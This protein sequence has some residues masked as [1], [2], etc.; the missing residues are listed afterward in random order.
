MTDDCSHNV[1]VVSKYV[2]MCEL[3]SECSYYDSYPQRVPDP[4]SLQEADLAHLVNENSNLALQK[5]ELLRVLVK[6]ID[7]MTSRPGKC[8]LFSYKFQVETGCPVGGYSRPIH[9]ALRPAV[10]SQ[11]DQMILWKLETHLS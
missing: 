7:N 5:K 1:L 10:K 6:Y 11:I 2:P 8:K 3:S 4:R 9:F